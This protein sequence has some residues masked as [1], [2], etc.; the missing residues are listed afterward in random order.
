MSGRFLPTLAAISV[1]AASQATPQ[2][3]ALPDETPKQLGLV[4]HANV[5]LAQIDVSLDGP[6]ERIASLTVDQFRVLVA[7]RDVMP[8][9]MDRLCTVPPNASTEA[10]RAPGESVTAPAARTS[11]LFY[12]DQ[13][14]LNMI[15]HHNSLDVAKGMISKLV[16]NGNRAAI[17]SSGKRVVTFATFTSRRETLLDALDRIRSDLTQWDDYPTLERK[18]ELEIADT[19]YW[20]KDAACQHAGMYQRE[21]L[22]RSYAALDRFVSVLGR[23]ADMDSPKVAIYFGDTLRSDPGR[24]YFVAA[25]GSCEKKSFTDQ[26]SFQQVHERASTLGVKLYAVQGEG[27]TSPDMSGAR[28]ARASAEVDAQ[29]GLK[30]LTLETGGDAFLN[31]ASVDSMTHK[32]EAD[33][34]CVYVLSFDPSPFP[35]DKPLPVSV[36]LAV[37][38]VRVRTRTE[39]VIQSESAR[40]MS[41]LLAA[42]AAPDDARDALPLQCGIVPLELNGGKLR[43]LVQA[44]L[45]ET[46]LAGE[47]WDLGMSLVSGSTVT[48][49]ASGRISAQRAGLRLVLE[50]EMEIRP[51]PF[52]LSVVAMEAATARLATG[53]I[54]GDWPGKITSPRVTSTALMQPTDGAFLRDGKLRTSGSL[55]VADVEPV[56]ADRPTAFVTLVCKAGTSKAPI[57]IHRSL[58]GESPTTFPPIVLPAKG[59]SCL[60]VRDVIPAN[61][62]TPGSF[63]YAVT[64]EGTEAAGSRAFTVNQRTE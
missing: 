21:E 60:Q 42:F 51:G 22:S 9:A 50:S 4:E 59:E 34:A 38:G 44:S 46:K 41:T 2:S 19:P 47:E 48:H 28:A 8:S 15:G 57:P 26:L 53:R 7:G 5:H 14:N 39:L 62:L 35:E 52:D 10:G 1:A 61:T 36:T 56:R 23:F 11:Y 49:Q 55:I 63:K 6:P 30:N 54:A 29:G 43:V 12:F 27:I 18:R 64:I 20:D 32:I 25:G 40:R 24:H 37:K 31:G 3:S 58:T 16:V 45:P 33:G 17:V 13:R